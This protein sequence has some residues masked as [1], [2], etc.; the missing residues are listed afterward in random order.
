MRRLLIEGGRLVDP[1]QG[2]DGERDLLIEE[3]RVAAV[4]SGLRGELPQETSFVELS[5]SGEAIDGTVAV[6]DARGLVV[7]PGFVDLH[8]HL[9]E[10]GFEYKETIATGTWAAVAGG[11]TAVACMPNTEPANDCGAVTE[12]ILQEAAAAGA[13]RVWPVGAVSR[14]RAGRELAEIGDMAEAGCVALSDDGAPVLDSGLMRRAMEYA[15]RFGLTV[16]DHCEDTRL[17]GGG[18]VHEGPVATE[19]GLGGWPAV[20]EEVLVA[21]NILLSE[22]L[23]LPIHLAHLSTAGSVRLLREAKS[24]GVAVTGE[25][26]PHH[27]VLTDEAIRG[28]DTN[29][30]MNPPLRSDEHRKALREALADGTIDAVATDHAPHAASEKEV[31][32]DQAAFGV[33]GLETALALVLKLVEEGLL[34]LPQAVER[35]TAGPARCLG[36]PGGTLAEG[37]AADLVVFDPG[38]AWTVDPSKFYSKGRNT[39]FAGWEVRGRA[40][41]TIVGGRVVYTLGGGVLV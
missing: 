38:A 12:F 4:G 36:F 6:L 8:V 41:A 32:F 3:G 30:K 31:E 14:G 25:V 37:G 19:M 29:A 13:C 22:A 28:Y 17:T 20:A 39:P 26:S 10:P 23:G 24:R 16:I 18:V 5:A 40:V 33:V 35:L 9:R 1:A 11:F 27:L 7:A 21:R 15:A 2:V 34:S